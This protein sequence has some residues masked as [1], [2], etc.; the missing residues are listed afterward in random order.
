MTHN[1]PD[2]VTFMSDPNKYAAVVLREEK[3]MRLRKK[4]FYERYAAEESPR[5]GC[6]R[7]VRI[8]G[9]TCGPCLNTRG[10]SIT[11]GVD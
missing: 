5:C 2:E 4:E 11:A 7:K 6:G 8:T 1:L 3:D 9:D 10:G